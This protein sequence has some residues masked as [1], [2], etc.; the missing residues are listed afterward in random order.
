[1]G[2]RGGAK[3]SIPPNYK[4]NSR[5]VCHRGPSAGWSSDFHTAWAMSCRL[6]PGGGVDR[7]VESSLMNSCKQW[8]K[9]SHW[10]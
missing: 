5:I 1:V 6:R 8:A 4:I 10:S 2:A 3:R 7:A 9:E